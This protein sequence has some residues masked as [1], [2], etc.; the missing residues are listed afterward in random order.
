MLTIIYLKKK[1][2]MQFLIGRVYL[3]PVIVSDD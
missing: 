2:S 1:K 3:H